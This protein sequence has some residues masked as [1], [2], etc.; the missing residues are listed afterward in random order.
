MPEPASRLPLLFAVLAAAWLL[1]VAAW[2]LG[3]WA[4]ATKTW[5]WPQIESMLGFVAGDK[6]EGTTLA[7][8][9]KN[10]FG[11]KPS[12]H[13][14][15]SQRKYEAPAG[16][17]ELAGLPIRDRRQAPL[18]HLDDT[19]PAGF[20][21]LYGTFDFEDGLHGAVLLGPAGDIV[22][23]W[24]VSQEDAEWAERED[25]NVFPHG[26]EILPDGGLIVTFDG[27]SSMSRYGWCGDLVWRTK[28]LFHHAVSWDGA[29]SVWS[30]GTPDGALT[31]GEFAVQVAVDDGRVLSSIHMDH[32][33]PENPGIDIFGIKQDDKPK[34]STWLFDR[35][36]V[37]DV[38]PLPAALADAFPGFKAGDLLMSFRS[39]N[40]V[41]VLDPDTRKVK[42]WRQGLVRRQHDPDWNADGSISIFDNNMHRDYSRIFSIDPATFEATIPVDGADYDFYTWHRGKHQKLPGG[43]YLVTSTEQGRVFE[44][45]AD[46]AIVFEFINRYGDNGGQLA[47]SEARWLPTDFFEEMPTCAD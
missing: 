47:M 30:W 35:W 11:W 17:G 2:G 23:T 20:R 12:R 37:N 7:E 25:G 36:H 42:W 22:R 15:E 43:G 46:G 41:F 34:G 39:I 6:E 1:F 18:L 31:N 32:V 13:I 29:G 28:G 10:D 9:V 8:K 24:T 14:V 40:L 16:Y 45:D 33:W 5:P 3:A 26:M 19:A 38:E 21:L 44:T 4:V 27:G